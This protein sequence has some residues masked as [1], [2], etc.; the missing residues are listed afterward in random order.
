MKFS[1]DVNAEPACCVLT[2]M[3]LHNRSRR[4][5]RGRQYS[6][7]TSMYARRVLWMFHPRSILMCLSLCLSNHLSQYIKSSEVI[8]RIYACLHA[9]LVKKCEEC[10]ENLI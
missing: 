10:G 4:Y 1:E 7:P 2:Y 5:Q 8:E 9:N 6:R 3:H